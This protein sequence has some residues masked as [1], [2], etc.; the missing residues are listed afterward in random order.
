M[1]CR[2][3]IRPHRPS[4]RFF[5]HILRTHAAAPLA[6]QV[7]FTS[8]SSAFA[9]MLAAPTSAARFSTTRPSARQAC[10]LPSD[11]TELNLKHTHHAAHCL[12]RYLLELAESFNILFYG[13]SSKRAAPDDLVRMT[14]QARTHA[15][16]QR[17]CPGAL[18]AISLQCSRIVPVH[19]KVSHSPLCHSPLL[20]LSPQHRRNGHFLLIQQIPFNVY[21]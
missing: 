16:H 1:P 4:T 12:L 15:F 13:L 5:T 7:A 3:A 17:L 18:H 10:P 14:T 6:R 9:L 21:I 8:R 11:N 19:S 2:R 20:L